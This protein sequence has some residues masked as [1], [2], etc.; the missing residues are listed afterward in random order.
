MITDFL[1]GEV[2]NTEGPHGEDGFTFFALE[3]SVAS[4]GGG[5]IMAF[6]PVPMGPVGM[7]ELMIPAFRIGT[8]GRI[9]HGILLLL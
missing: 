8:I 1:F 7:I 3:P 2:I 6:M 4:S 5:M 9:V